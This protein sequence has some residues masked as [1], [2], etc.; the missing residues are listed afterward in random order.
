MVYA[1]VHKYHTQTQK[2]KMN[3]KEIINKHKKR[4][5]QQHKRQVKTMERCFL[6][7]SRVHRGTDGGRKAPQ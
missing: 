4:P 6:L 3:G 1:V 7:I 5:K 2:Q